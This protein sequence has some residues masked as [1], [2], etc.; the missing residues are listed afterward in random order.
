MKRRV[1]E[2]IA[3][4]MYGMVIGAGVAAV[5]TFMVNN[6]LSEAQLFL[7][8]CKTAAAPLA[9]AVICKVVLVRGTLRH[10]QAQL[11]AYRS[12]EERHVREVQER[13]DFSRKFNLVVSNGKEP[14]PTKILELPD[15]K[16][17][18]M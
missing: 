4:V 10:Y 7:T 14:A 2:S 8:C 12:R 3:R 5:T 15:L 11:R 6:D 16:R 1:R 18:T 13:A 17:K 9:V